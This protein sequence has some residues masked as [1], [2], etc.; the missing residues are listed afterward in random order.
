[1]SPLSHSDGHNFPGGFDEAVPGLATGIDDG[2]VVGEDAAGKIGLAQ[3]LPDV[4]D[5][6]EF[7]CAR[8]QQDRRNIVRHLQFPRG[9]PTGTIHQQDGMSA[10]CDGLGD[11]AEMGLHGVGVGNRHHQ[12]GAGSPGRADGAEQVHA[13]VALVLGLARPTSSPRPLPHQAVFLSPTTLIPSCG[14]SDS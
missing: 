5:R 4:L 11:L 12:R 1:V 8:W 14:M 7:G 10:G 13:L 2:P 6:I 3:V 9:V